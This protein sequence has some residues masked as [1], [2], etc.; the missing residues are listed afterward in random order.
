[1]GATEDYH[2]FFNIVKFE[3][4]GNYQFFT[5]TLTPALSSRARGYLG[6][7]FPFYDSIK[8]L[9]NILDY[10]TDKFLRAHP[11]RPES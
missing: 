8:F 3:C 10:A 9:G 1:L 7:F 6:V 4:A 2:S 5:F 11:G